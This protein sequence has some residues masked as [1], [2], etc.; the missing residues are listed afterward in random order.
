MRLERRQAK[1]ILG[2]QQN[3]ERFWTNLKPEIPQ[4]IRRC[5]A[6]AQGEG[7]VVRPVPIKQTILFKEHSFCK[8]I[9]LTEILDLGSENAI[10]TYRYMDYSYYWYP[11]NHK[12]LHNAHISGEEKY[13]AIHSF[14]HFA[15]RK[16]KKLNW[17]C[18]DSWKDIIGT[19]CRQQATNSE[20]GNRYRYNAL[21]TF[22]DQKSNRNKC[23]KKC[24][25]GV[26]TF[27]T[28]PV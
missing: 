26:K 7:V 16:P 10:I 2:T 14:Q 8:I 5:G 15:I 22:S 11:L 3:N 18:E 25:F 27:H 12:S 21:P 19:K 13:W 23:F 6:P 9:P 4:T 28:I 24:E 17:P 20:R 1:R